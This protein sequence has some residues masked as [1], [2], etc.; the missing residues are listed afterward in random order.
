MQGKALREEVLFIIHLLCVK[1]L[2]PPSSGLTKASGTDTMI[3]PISQK[4][5]LDSKEN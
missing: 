1:H 3:V 4:G 5:K 2:T